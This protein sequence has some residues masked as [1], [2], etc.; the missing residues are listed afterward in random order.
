MQA[1][2]KKVWRSWAQISQVLRAENATPQMC[3]VF[4]KVTIVMVV[5]LYG[6][7][8]WN[9]APSSLKVLKDSTSG[10]PVVWQALGLGGIQMG[11][12]DW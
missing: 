5:L 2:L 10:P 3:G 8:T 6:S 11:L 7:E 4:Y 12:I 1:N 9:L